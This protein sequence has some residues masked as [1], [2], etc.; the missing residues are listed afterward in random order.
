MKL[1]AFASH[2]S[3]PLKEKI[4]RCSCLPTCK[5][6]DAYPWFPI[7]GR[8][9]LYRLR[10]QHPLPLCP[11]KI[12]KTKRQK[13]LASQNLA[14]KGVT[15]KILHPK[16][17]NGMAC[18]SSHTCHTIH[19][20]GHPPP[21]MS[22]QNLENKEAEKILPRKILKP[23]ELHVIFLNPKDLRAKIV[24]SPAQASFGL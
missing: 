14:C 18:M 1:A 11:R 4:G 19:V 2:C 16:D 17:L 23:K 9:K 8:W 5:I 13:K 21:P 3:G 12:L 7:L 22:L 20:S 6:K 10:R 15:R 24:V